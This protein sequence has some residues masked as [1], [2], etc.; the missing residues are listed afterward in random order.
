[1]EQLDRLGSAPFAKEQTCETC[2]ETGLVGQQRHGIL[3]DVHRLRTR[4]TGQVEPDRFMEHLGDRCVLDG[5]IQRSNHV[6]I[7]RFG[8]TQELQLDEVRIGVGR[9]TLQHFVDAG[10]CHVEPRVGLGPHESK[11]G[12]NHR[13]IVGE[14]ELDTRP[15]LSTH[16]QA[17]VCRLLKRQLLHTLRFFGIAK[18]ALA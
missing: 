16:R 13:V 17:V 3:E 4:A 2:L 10:G 14:L 9:G 11:T 15:L 6:F 7:L 1:M 5:R 12:L 18:V 8:P